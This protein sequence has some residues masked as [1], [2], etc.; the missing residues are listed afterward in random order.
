[1]LQGWTVNR[2]LRELLD[3]A[4]HCADDELP[5]WLAALLGDGLVEEGGALLLRAQVAGSHAGPEAFPDLTGYEAFVN[6]FHVDATSTGFADFQVACRA[7]DELEHQISRWPHHGPVR[8]LLSRNLSGP[9]TSSTVRFHRL[10]P[11][12]VWLRDNLEGYE[13]EAVGFHD[14]A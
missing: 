9:H 10:R 3:A 4:E 8:V 6:H 5:A 12:E 1:M 2:A 11:G 13:T 14:L 7:V